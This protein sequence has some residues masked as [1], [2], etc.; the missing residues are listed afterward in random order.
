MNDA[1]LDSRGGRLLVGLAAGAAGL[2]GSYAAAGY[3]PTFVASPVER[4]LSRTM[5][6]EIVT[7]AITYLGSL[8]QQLN[9]VTAVVLTWLVFA[10]GATAAILAGRAANNRVLPA[11]GTGVAT[12]LVTA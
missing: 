3:T 1:L 11:L 6:G 9:L 7:F 4:T 12:W 2:A 5:P 8:G 10:A